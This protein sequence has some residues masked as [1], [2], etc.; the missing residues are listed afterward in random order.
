MKNPFKETFITQL[1]NYFL[2]SF[3]KLSGFQERIKNVQLLFEGA[4]KFYKALQKHY[5]KWTK[6]AFLM[7]TTKIIF[8]KV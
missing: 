3:K 5:K 2:P 1:R 4:Y 7:K 8:Q 6:I